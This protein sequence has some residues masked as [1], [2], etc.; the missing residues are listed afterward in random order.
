VTALLPWLAALGPALLF[1]PGLLP[2]AG[3]DS[4]PRDM[5]R[6][7]L[8]AALA[9]AGLAVLVAV[10]LVAFG[11]VP[12]WLVQ[13][14]ALS[15]T[16]LVLVSGI[17][18][19]V[20]AYSR[21][22][23]DG[24]PGQ[25][26]FMRWL[27]LTL[28][29]VLV[30]VVAGNL[31]LFAAAWVATG[32]FLH[33]LLLFYPERPAAQAAAR[34]R[35]LA[36]RI[37]DACL[38]AAIALVW[39]SFGTLGF[40]ELSAAAR[41]MAEPG[42]AVHAATL[43]LA[44]AALIKSAQ[45]PVHGWL[46]EVMETPTPVSALLHAGII[47]AG[48]FLVLRMADVMAASAP[49]LDLLL[50]V[51]ALTACFGAAVML[52]QTSVKVQ[53][54]WSTIAQMGFMMMQCGLGAFASALLHIVAHAS[55]RRTPS[56]P[57]ARS[58]MR[59]GGEAG[60]AARL[61]PAAGA[62][63]LGRARARH[64][65]AVRHAGRREAGRRGARRGAD[66]GPCA[67]ARRLARRAGHRAACTPR[68]RD[69]GAGLRRLLRAAG[70]GGGAAR[71]SAAGG[72]GAARPRGRPA[73]G[74]GRR[75]LRDAVGAE[76]DAPR[77]RAQPACAGA[78]RPPLQRLLPQHR[79][80]PPRRADLAAAGDPV[81][82]DTLLHPVSAVALEQRLRQAC[83][84]VAPL[85][86]LQD[87][88]AVNP[89]VGL[90][91]QRFDQAAQTLRRVAGQDMLP[92]RAL[93][94]QA[95]AEGR[96]GA[97]DLAAAGAALPDAPRPAPEAGTALVAEV[98]DRVH[99]TAWSRFAVEEI[100]KWVAAWADEGQAGWAMPW[101]DRP[102]HAAWRAA[103]R[104][105][106]NPEVMG[107][108]GFRAAL[109][110]LPET[111]V[112]SIAASLAAIGMAPAEAEDYLHR[113]ILS[114]S[115]WAGLLRGRGWLD[116]DTDG[117]LELLAIRLAWDATLFTLHTDAPFRDA[118]RAVLEAPPPPAPDLSADMRL[119]DAYEG[120]WRRGLVSQLAAP[121]PA[122]TAAAVQAVF[123]IDVRSE[124]Y[125]RALEAA[126]PQ[127]ETLGFA[128]FFGFA[129]DYVR[130]GE[131]RGAA[132]CPVL[133]RP[134]MTVC[135]TVAG[136]SPAESARILER[137]GL[138]RR[139]SDM[140]A[141]L[142][143]SAVSCFAYVET[144]GFAAALGLV[145]GALRRPAAAD[146]SG[147]DPE[148]FARLAPDV[149]P[150]SWRGRA[151]GLATEARIGAAETVLRAMSLTEGFGGLVLLAGHGGN[152]VNNPHAA[153]LDC[154]ACG[155][156]TGESNARIAA[157]VLNDP[158]V[159]EGLAARGIRIPPTPGSWPRC[160]TRPPTR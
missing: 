19:V 72:C 127:V 14:D 155:G 74:A 119:L 59:A 82:P 151:T 132:Q 111:P 94:A 13:L 35:F 68:G 71:R 46:P 148:V 128:G 40:A 154:G 152:T 125:R 54:A 58:P 102:L 27:S 33:R 129:A 65:R 7:V 63:R 141:N 149:A 77:R 89:F 38:F 31:V 98:L 143:V 138:R 78:A 21:R 88:V 106:R 136:A 160:T 32:L 123:C 37:G 140:W 99:G 30:L 135:E 147:L 15:G 158:L 53:L 12:G 131:A 137:Q 120:A 139:L 39:T 118:W 97:A 85:W 83:A 45:L 8:G 22:Y 61:P 93:F 101:R 95:A 43:L 23:L 91:G 26:R 150:G 16:M 17:G 10:G 5:R 107:L 104:H 134:G 92:P 24:D 48:G 51:G 124:V 18:A 76:R 156:H 80:E 122:R 145:R 133:L 70:R 56:S 112:E 96:I 126:S 84:R 81:M 57:P 130:F 20:V 87:F 159:R 144:A 108:R 62:R 117:V 11:P 6:L 44:L 66:D 36:N 1:L 73:L 34:K 55:T 41:G 64:R 115:G 116:Q 25:G 28:A 50:M 146:A 86:P 109:A 79:H 69:R 49:A 100:G 103:M 9:N 113:A 60:A 110:R 105:D 52:T 114:V 3:A 90:A 153:G 67:D 75:L 47:N 2:D 157:A 121:R 29:S 42:L 4:R 142:R